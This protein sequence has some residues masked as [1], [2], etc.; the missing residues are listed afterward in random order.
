[1]EGLTDTQERAFFYIGE[2][3]SNNVYNS[4]ADINPLGAFD[5]DLPDVGQK[6]EELTD[7]KAFFYIGES[8]FCEDDHSGAN[9]NPTTVD[10]DLAD[11]GSLMERLSDRKAFY[12]FGENKYKEDDESEVNIKY[13][14][15]SSSDQ[16]FP[17]VNKDYVGS[18]FSQG[19]TPKMWSA[20]GS[21]RW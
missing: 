16:L 12:N 21:K 1:M 18:K 6:L 3:D 2:N 17:L 20:E 10:R 19:L 8:D 4:E 15:R 5:K 7:R 9:V 14:S 11:V 13:P